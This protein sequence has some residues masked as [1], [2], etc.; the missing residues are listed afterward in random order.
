MNDL[1]S[2]PRIK[3]GA[4]EYK[5]MALRECQAPTT[6]C[7]NPEQFVSYWRTSVETSPWY[8]RDRE[9]AVAIMVNARRKIRGHYLIAIGTIDSV[10]IAPRDV[11]R[12]A[13]AVSAHSVIIGHNHP[14]G[15]PIP[16]E[17]DIR[18]TRELIRA[19]QI[20]KVE[21]LDHLVI[22]SPTATPK[23]YASLRELGYFYS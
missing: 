19:G 20:L 17:S 10:S 15:D 21:L 2:I 8:D 3:T 11:F 7:E 14:S 18:V 16:S 13:I 5:L 22:G 4:Y 1:I 12:L 6:P 23:T 9:Q